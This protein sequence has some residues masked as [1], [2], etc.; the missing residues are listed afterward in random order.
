MAHKSIEELRGRKAKAFG[1]GDVKHTASFHETTSSDPVNPDHY[2][3][4]GKGFQAIDVIE[5]ATADAPDGFC[6]MLQGNVIKYLYRTWRKA[7]PLEDLKKAR[8]YLDKLIARLE[9]EAR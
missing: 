5:E 4:N 1:P 7:K 6:G 8:W 2:Q 9:D 3:G